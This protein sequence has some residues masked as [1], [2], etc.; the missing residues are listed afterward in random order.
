MEILAMVGLDRLR[1]RP[2]PQLSGGQQQRVALARAVV[3]RPRVLL[4]DEPLSNLDAKLRLDMRAEIRRICKETGLTTI[5]V[6]H[7]QKE[8]L[9]MADRMAVLH[10]GRLVQLGTPQEVYRRPANRFVADF[11]GE[12]NFVA[13]RITRRTGLEAEVDTPWGHL[14]STACQLA[15]KTGDACLVSVRPES[16]RFTDQPTGPNRLDLT[17]AGCTY[18][19]EMAQWLL[20]A[21]TDRLKVVELQPRPRADGLAVTCEVSAD[22]VVVLPPET[23]GAAG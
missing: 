19:G 17:V 13:G 9:S 2:I 12:S 22:D 16:I 4:L 5:H 11:I 14:H 1:D 10:Q 8:A 21:G 7:D 23:A 18:L 15:A 3:I 6:T 20:A